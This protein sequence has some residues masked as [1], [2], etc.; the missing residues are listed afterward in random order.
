[1]TAKDGR[2][3]LPDGVSYR[4]MILPIDGKLTDEARQQIEK[5]RKQGVPVYDPQTDSRS[6][7]EAICEAGLQPDVEAPSAKGLYFAHRTT[8][9]EDIYFLNNHSD[10]DVSD[11]FRFNSEAKSAELWNPVTGERTVLAMQTESGRTAINLTLHARESYFVILSH[12]ASTNSNRVTIPV[13]QNIQTV[14][15]PWQVQF[16]ATV[17]GPKNPVPF[18]K[19]GDWTQSSDPH[20]KYFSGTAVA[21]TTF[22]MGKPDQQAH[23]RL[24]VPLL[25]TTAEVIV[26][27]QSAGIIWCSP[28]SLDITH[29]LKK[30]KNQ[31]E[32]R[33]ANSL[34]NRLVGDATF[35][36]SERIYWQTHPLA[37][38]SDELVP[39]GIE[40]DITISF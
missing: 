6:L 4:M 30:G 37:K 10:E 9:S 28:Y 34:W 32:L 3:V 18:D 22:Q 12:Q 27:G 31:L 33:I 7:E 8:D 14:C 26:N 17:G 35:P 29:F 24:N 20:I 36:E 16:D 5:F 13:E 39:S 38:P 25:N 11:C 2:I 21:K 23:Y 1:M 15:T 19:L 40:G